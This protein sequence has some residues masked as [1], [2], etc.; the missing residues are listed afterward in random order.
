MT[1]ADDD[2][3][4]RN[5]PQWGM[6]E[7][8]QQ[9]AAKEKDAAAREAARMERFTRSLDATMEQYMRQF[10]PPAPKSQGVRLDKTPDVKAR[11]TGPLSPAQLHHEAIRAQLATMGV[12]KEHQ[13]LRILM[14][15][16]QA[17]APGTDTNSRHPH[18]GRSSDGRGP[19]RGKG[20]EQT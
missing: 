19:E 13:D 8:P 4:R 18:R 1:D 20:R 2:K 14:E 7:T 12:S 3:I 9:R 11:Y 15:L 5:I 10:R 16:G 6:S 17:Q